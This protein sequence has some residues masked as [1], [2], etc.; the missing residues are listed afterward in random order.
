MLDIE[1]LN[2]LLVA[3]VLL[4]STFNRSNFAALMQYFKYVGMFA[5]CAASVGDFLK[6]KYFLKVTKVLA[7][8]SL[9]SDR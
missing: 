9:L 2:A 1:L 6:L 7:L 4:M 3:D 5:Y 8:A